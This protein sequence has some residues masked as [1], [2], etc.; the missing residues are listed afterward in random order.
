MVILNP[1]F[2]RKDSRSLIFGRIL[3]DLMNSLEQ[4]VAVSGV[5]LVAVAPQHQA[6]L[7]R[8]R[9][10]RRRVE[11]DGLAPLQIQN[12][13]QCLS[14]TIVDASTTLHGIGYTEDLSKI[15]KTEGSYDNTF[16]VGVFS[17]FCFWNR[18]HE[19]DTG[20]SV[21]LATGFC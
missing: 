5:P 8:L 16:H 10:R 14:M 18:K 15:C 7:D 6:V 9:A 2:Y 13:Y 19:K 17:E 1:L 21:R 4:P 12:D 20:G 3:S 11:E